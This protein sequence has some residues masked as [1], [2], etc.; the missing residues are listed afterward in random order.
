MLTKSDFQ[1]FRHCQKCFWLTARKPDAIAWPAPSAFVRMLMKDG[2][3]VEAEMKRLIATRPDRDRFSAQ[4]V[5][6][7]ADLFARADFVR[8]HDDDAI[9]LF[10]VKASTGVKAKGPGDHITDVAFQTHA[11]RACGFVVR[12]S[13]IVHVNSDYVRNGDIDP[14]T[15]LTIVDVT[16]QVEERLAGLSEEIGE[17]LSLLEQASINENGC[18]CMLFGSPDN[19]CA[20]FTYFNPEVPEP[21]IY[22]LPRISAKK[23][24]KFVDEGRLLLKDV[25]PSELSD[26]KSVV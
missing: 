7:T 14:A 2:Y 15:L 20:A 4:Q 21:S 6:Q 19:R 11:A 10:E 3:A 18:S 5:F 24:A 26:R 8:R 25:D 16:D 22:L 1:S 23:V 12:S 13:H 9:D 17:A